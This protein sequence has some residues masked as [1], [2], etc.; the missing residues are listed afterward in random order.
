MHR[1]SKRLLLGAALLIVAAS[2][3]VPAA[4][5]EQPGPGSGSTSVVE[6]VLRMLDEGVGSPVILDWLKRQDRPV[7]PLSPDDLIGLTRAGASEELVEAL[8]EKSADEPPAPP[9]PAASKSTVDEPPG[10]PADGTAGVAF[11]LVYRSQS[12]DGTEFDKRWAMFAYLDGEPLLWSTSSG[13]FSRKSSNTSRRL[14]PGPHVIRLTRESHVKRGKRG[15]EH[16]SLVCPD[17]IVFN[18]EAGEGWYLSITWV[19]PAFTLKDKRPLS[20]KLTR[21]DG[22][23]AGVEKTGQP[24][25]KWRHLCEDAQANVPEG[26]KPPASVRPQLED[27]T[28]WS[29]L[30][31]GEE[32]AFTRA[33]LLETLE[34]DDFR[35]PTD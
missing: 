34:K 5:Q 12:D 2:G 10:A 23:V 19:E 29:T 33:E 8:I 31:S 13:S 14:D 20:W 27:C 17:P 6:D 18:V 21:W 4:D 11:S 7:K 25:E 32:P 15:W 35:P 28:K 9:P 24:K 30:W 3:P 26:K 22:D 16:E 1:L